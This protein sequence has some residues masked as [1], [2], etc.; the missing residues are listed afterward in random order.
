[1]RFMLPW[2]IGLGLTGALPFSWQAVFAHGHTRVESVMALLVLG[3]VG[4][5]LGTV[6]GAVLWMLDLWRYR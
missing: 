3:A 2:A 5:A 4:I 6:I 1:M